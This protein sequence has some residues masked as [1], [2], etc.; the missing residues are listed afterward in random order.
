MR[1]QMEGLVKQRSSW[2]DAAIALGGAGLFLWLA[3]YIMMCDT[4]VQRADWL[5][6]RVKP[7]AYAASF[8][9]VCAMIA[10][11]GAAVGYLRAC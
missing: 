11:I 6:E 5:G 8:A 2:R 7:F 9:F 1:G 10:G 3:V 4:C